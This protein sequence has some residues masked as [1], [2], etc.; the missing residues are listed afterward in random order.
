MY[1]YLRRHAVDILLIKN[2]L[3]KFQNVPAKF[4][5]KTEQSSKFVGMNSKI[6]LLNFSMNSVI[7]RLPG[8]VNLAYGTLFRISLEVLIKT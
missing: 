5:N 7:S 4:Q 3:V 1:A 8:M 6:F 2:T